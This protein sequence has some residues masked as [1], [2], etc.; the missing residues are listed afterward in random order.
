MQ[1]P[2]LALNGQHLLPQMIFSMYVSYPSQSM[3]DCSVQIDFLAA[4]FS[5]FPVFS[6]C[7]PTKLRI[8][9]CSMGGRL[10]CPV[11]PQ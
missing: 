10:L 11:R 3:C 8:A 1:L 2:I 4:L 5:C 6:L 7:L 9:I